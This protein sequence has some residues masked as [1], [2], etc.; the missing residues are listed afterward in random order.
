MD[1][2][3]GID[4]SP[5]MLDQARSTGLYS[6]LEEREMLQGLRGMPEAGADLI[7][8]ADAM[9]YV[10]DFVPVLREAARVLV[11]GGLLAFTAETHDGHGVIVGAGLR[12]A[13][14]AA[15]VREAIDAAGLVLA[16][17]DHLSARNE[18]N[19]PVPGLVVV[20]AK[21]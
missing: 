6:G 20:A 10:G 11:A 14:G 15:Y 18:D 4:I 1:S 12:Y 7:I 13:H 19:A 3:T 17:L 9:V 16:R 21:A 8:A 2:F 5:R